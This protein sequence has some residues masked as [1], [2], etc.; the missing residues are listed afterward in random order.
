MKTNEEKVILINEESPLF[1]VPNY[2]RWNNAKWHQKILGK[3]FY[4]YKKRFIDIEG[5]VSIY[6]GNGTY[7]I[8]L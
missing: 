6:K 3:I 5:L 7:E 2:D 1:G 4:R 8:K